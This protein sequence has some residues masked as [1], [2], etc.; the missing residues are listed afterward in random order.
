MAAV[1]VEVEEALCADVGSG[2]GEGEGRGEKEGDT[3]FAT[4][5]HVRSCAMGAEK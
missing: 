5:P 4:G 2:I 3:T 1:V